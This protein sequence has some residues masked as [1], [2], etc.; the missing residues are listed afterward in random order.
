[1]SSSTSAP[2]QSHRDAPP[3][4]FVSSNLSNFLWYIIFR[5]GA[6]KI[7]MAARKYTHITEIECTPL[8]IYSLLLSSVISR[9]LGLLGGA[10]AFF[11]SSNQKLISTELS[12]KQTSH[13]E[14]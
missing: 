8:P 13:A 6:A 11:L 9:Q 10:E 4:T 14:A 5:K 2:I 12:D 3:H 1:M 7:Q